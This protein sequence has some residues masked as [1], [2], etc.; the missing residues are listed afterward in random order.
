MR[1]KC[2]AIGNRIMGDDAIGIK[3]TEKLHPR[4][5]REGIKV[6]YG[7]TDV[8]YALDNIES[9]DVIFIIDA[10]YL[11]NNPGTVTCLT[12]QDV[13]KKKQV[14]SQHELNLVDLLHT[15]NKSVKGYVI[16]IEIQRLDFSL[17]LSDSL[18]YKFP[19]ICEEVYS[20]IMSS[21]RGL[22]HA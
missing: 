16:G 14:Y 7:E 19:T 22:T 11:G 6:I 21:I 5:T 2:I 15:Y 12:L 4:L 9:R 18:I 1:I 13:Y 8:N 17:E 10:T 3:V 20:V